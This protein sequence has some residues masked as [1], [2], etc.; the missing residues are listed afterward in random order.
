MSQEIGNR[1][2][3][4]NCD[5]ACINCGSISR[6]HLIAHRNEEGNICGFLVCCNGCRYKVENGNLII[7][8]KK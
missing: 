8:E 7:E 5:I 6:V 4:S 2:E 3:R 1:D